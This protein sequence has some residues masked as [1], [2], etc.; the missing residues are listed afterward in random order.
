MSI[1][2]EEFERGIHS[3][4]SVVFLIQE[5]WI[6][7]IDGKTS[8]GEHVWQKSIVHMV[9]LGKSKQKKS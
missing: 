9:R 5:K 6:I 2:S 4:G 3:N 8:K 1:D 7:A